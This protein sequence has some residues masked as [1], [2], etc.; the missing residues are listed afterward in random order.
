MACLAEAVIAPTTPK[1]DT[2][3]SLR[4]NPAAA[5]SNPAAALS[6]T[7]EV[8]AVMCHDIITFVADSLTNSIRQRILLWSMFAD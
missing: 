2:P 5:L 1:S 7:L 4:Q 3:A 6:C 8:L